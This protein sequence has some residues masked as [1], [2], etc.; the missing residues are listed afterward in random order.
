MLAQKTRRKKSQMGG[1]TA[2]GVSSRGSKRCMLDIPV[3]VSDNPMLVVMV[4][5]WNTDLLRM[6]G[7]PRPIA[8]CLLTPS[9]S[10][11]SWKIHD[12]WRETSRG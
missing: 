12:S 8:L 9:A 5:D 4:E 6:R 2:E 3:E 1:R 10:V 11:C 7:I